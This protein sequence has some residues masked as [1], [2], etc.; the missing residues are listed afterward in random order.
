MTRSMWSLLYL[1]VSYTNHV[2]IWAYIYIS[3]EFIHIETQS[4][5]HLTCDFKCTILWHVRFTHT[6]QVIC[7]HL[8][9]LETYP[10]SCSFFFLTL[11]TQNI[12]KRLRKQLVDSL[13]VQQKHKGGL[14]DLLMCRAVLATESADM[15]RLDG[16]FSVGTFMKWMAWKKSQPKSADG[17]PKLCFAS[18]QV[19]WFPKFGW[20][21]V[22]SVARIHCVKILYG[23]FKITT[24]ETW[25]FQWIYISGSFDVRWRCWQ[26]MGLTSEE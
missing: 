21:C 1:V 4:L 22:I 17:H 11:F 10:F 7:F 3:R 24:V 18:F 14:P 19:T 23:H 2:Y 20:C 26:R 6:L 9:T 15:A 16:F 25:D 5:A 8:T 12:S 13:R